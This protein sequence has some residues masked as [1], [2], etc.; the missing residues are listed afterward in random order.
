LISLDKKLWEILN[1]QEFLSDRRK[2]IA[3]AINK[4]M[5]KYE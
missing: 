2:A 1:F 3:E 4:F 5:K